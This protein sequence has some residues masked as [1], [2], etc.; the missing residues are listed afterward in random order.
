MSIKTMPVWKWVLLLIASFILALVMYA[1]S[2]LASDAVKPDFLKWFVSII[3]SVVMIALY[4][5]FVQW[6]EKQPA[7]DI[8]LRKIPADTGKG[9]AIG[10]VFMLAVT[11]IMM[12]CGLY[13]ID[14]VRTDDPIPLVTAFF[15]FLYVA[16][17]EEILFRGVLFRWIDE[18]WGFAAALTIS[19][20]LFGAMHIAQPNASWWSSLAI[21][22]E[23]GLLLGA[24]YKW[25][26]TLWFPI[27]IHWAWNFFQGNIFGFA[28]SGS[29]AGASLLQSTVSGPEILTGG[30][31][32]AEASI[33]TVVLGSLL[34]AWFI[35]K[36]V[37]D[38]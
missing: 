23:A 36:A 21:A 24:A 14:A 11:L 37:K 33:I 7:K 20:L 27:G 17:G 3:V 32:G 2:Q 22:I 19:S 6:F 29:D 13:R 26:G 25:S 10:A 9:L 30:P 18:K 4:A 34:S 15:L 8:P 5:V 38:R 31:F 16:V 12:L 1:F 28:V 35:F